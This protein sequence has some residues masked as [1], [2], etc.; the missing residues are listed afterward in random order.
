MWSHARRREARDRFAA[1]SGTLVLA[2]PPPLSACST[3]DRRRVGAPGGTDSNGG[4]AG[5]TGQAGD[6]CLGGIDNQ[7]DASAPCK[8]PDCV[9]INPDLPLLPECADGCPTDDACRSYALGSVDAGTTASDSCGCAYTW[10][11]ASRDGAACVC[12]AAGCVLLAGEAC[13]TG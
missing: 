2:L 1:L 5:A 13:S 12:D 8:G 10:K 4:E 11:P 7:P 6:S 3:S 9:G